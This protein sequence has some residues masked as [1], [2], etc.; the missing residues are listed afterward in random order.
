MIDRR[1]DLR[2]ASSFLEEGHF[3]EMSFEW[4]S[5]ETMPKPD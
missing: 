5:S 2:A 3:F 4:T 1:N